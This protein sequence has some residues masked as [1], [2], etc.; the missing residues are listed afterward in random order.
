METMQDY[1]PTSCRNY[2]GSID[3]EPAFIIAFIKRDG[4][5]NQ[6]IADWV[7]DAAENID[8]RAQ[9]SGIDEGRAL[10]LTKV[11]FMP[12]YDGDRYRIKEK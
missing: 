9:V 10:H 11:L 6:A 7:L 5:A 12:A 2:L 3:G 4:P 8:E 1:N